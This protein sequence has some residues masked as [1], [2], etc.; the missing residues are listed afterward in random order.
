M[1]IS[2]RPRACPCPP[3]PLPAAPIPLSS[4]VPVAPSPPLFRTLGF[5][6]YSQFTRT[7]RFLPALYPHPPSRV[8]ARYPHPLLYPH[9]CIL[10][11]SGWLPDQ[12]NRFCATNR[13]V[14]I[15]TR[16]VTYLNNSRTADSILASALCGGAIG[17][18]NFGFP[19][20][21]IRDIEPSV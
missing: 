2:A 12:A 15:E 17:K 13:G 6:C 3:R 9:P 18:P 10:V 19:R 16:E 4:F 5:F 14:A 21:R 8:P 20:A 1:G 7:L 11:P